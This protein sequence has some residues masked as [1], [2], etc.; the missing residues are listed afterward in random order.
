MASANEKLIWT[1]TYTADE[2]M[3]SDQYHGVVMSA[4]RYVDLCD[5]DTDRCVGLLLNAPDDEEAAFVL[6]VGR[7][8]GVAAETLAYGEKVR[9]DSSGHVAKFEEETDRDNYCVGTVVEGA[10]SGEMVICNFSF[11]TAYKGEDS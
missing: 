8:P 11:P 9:I 3:T 7:A 5:A 6:I 10:A 4:D 2:E 1:E